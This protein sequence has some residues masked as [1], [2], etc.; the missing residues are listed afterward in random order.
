MR[1]FSLGEL[2]IDV[3]E[4]PGRL[5]LRWRGV[6]R[7]QN[8]GLLLTPFFESALELAA[9]KQLGL[10]L[11]FEALSYFNSSTVGVLLRFIEATVKRKVKMKLIYDKTQRWQG[12]NFEAIAALNR[13]SGLVEV[14]GV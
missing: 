5:V 1:D 2:K 14:E 13:L 3:S 12:H 11:R 6:C 10:E 7:E 9:D 8:P 4:P